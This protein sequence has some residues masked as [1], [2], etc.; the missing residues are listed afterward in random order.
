M[1]PSDKI[2]ETLLDIKI[3]PQIFH[4]VLA[5]D[6]FEAELSWASEGGRGGKHLWILK[7]SAKKVVF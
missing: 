1:W 5:Y 2:L 3:F 4:I 7:I 6:R